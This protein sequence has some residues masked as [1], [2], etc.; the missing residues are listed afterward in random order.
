[1]PVEVVGW[2]A[3]IEE[4]LGNIPQAISTAHIL[5]MIP[6]GSPSQISTGQCPYIPSLY[7]SKV[8]RP[9]AFSGWVR[10]LMGNELGPPCF[11]FEILRMSQYT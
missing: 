9:I 4:H 3:E 10:A 6:G 5:H 1:M 8:W 7:L 2:H 11:L